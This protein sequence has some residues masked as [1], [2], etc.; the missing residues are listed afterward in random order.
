MNSNLQS[1]SQST[2]A[3]ASVRTVLSEIDASIRFP[4]LFFVVSALVW[5]IIGSAF[6]LITAYQ[7]H[8]PMFMAGYEFVTYGRLYPVATNAMLFGWG[9]NSIFAIGLWIIARLSQAPFRN[10]GLLIVA[11]IFWN[12]GLKVGLFGILAGDLNAAEFL[13]LPGYAT[14]LLLVAYALIGAWGIMAFRARQGD[15]VYVS[16]W[17]ILGALF[18][19]P[20]IYMISEFLVVWFPARGV[21]QAV[22]ANWFNASIQN[23][24]LTPMALAVAYYVIPKVLGRP[25]HSYTLALLGFVSLALLG[26]WTGM[27]NLIGGPVPI[28][29]SSVS[30]VAAVMMVIPVL[31]VG[32]NLFMTVKG[33][34]A[35]VWRSP[36]LRFVMFGILSYFFASLVGSAM[37]F[38]SVSEIT[39]FTTFATG[40]TQHLVYGFFTMVMF[41]GLYYMLP[42][43]T[44]REWPSA[45]LIFFHFWGS[46]IGITTIVV[47]L[48]VGGWLAGVQMNNAE[49]P[50]LEIVRLME[51]W[52]EIRS[53]GVIC[54]AIGHIAFAINFIWMLCATGSFRAK[55]GPTLLESAN[56]EGA[57]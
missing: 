56:Q 7:S 43:L 13:E 6:T 34:K 52:L 51:P 12:L 38:R 54:L 33:R 47:S 28:W 30:I 4:A 9:C 50:F 37:A 16:Q 18:W 2:P 21:V 46:A 23:L 39:H 57:A 44:K 31:A 32:I 42:R 27:V 29:M 22:T 8:E 15:S 17:Y 14:P 45:T 19:F 53:I 35:D 41:G 26:S 36:A 1:N 24:W 10:G 5:L 11:G 20:W 3:S 25:I 40:Q 48:L 55:Q 49:V